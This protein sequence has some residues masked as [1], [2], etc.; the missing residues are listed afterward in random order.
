MPIFQRQQ[1]T[2]G[3]KH[4]KYSSSQILS[5]NNRG[6]MGV[7]QHDVMKGHTSTDSLS[8]EDE[9]ITADETM[10]KQHESFNKKGKCC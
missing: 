1:T 7:K 3:D 5:D 10:R 4:P 8:E 6:K 2:T 9:T